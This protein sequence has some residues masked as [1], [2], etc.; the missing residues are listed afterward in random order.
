MWPYHDPAAQVRPD[1][2]DA[3]GHGRGRCDD[4][5]RTAGGQ[6]H[7]RRFAP[8]GCPLGR[9]EPGLFAL[10]EEVQR[11]AQQGPP[12]PAG[13]DET[14]IVE[15]HPSAPGRAAQLTAH[16]PARSD[17]PSR[18]DDLDI[19]PPG[20][21]EVA[22]QLNQEPSGAAH[23]RP[24]RVHGHRGGHCRTPPSP[25]SDSSTQ[26]DASSRSGARAA[27]A[28]H[29]TGRRPASREAASHHRTAMALRRRPQVGV[30]PIPSRPVAVSRQLP[31]PG[32]SLGTPLRPPDGVPQIG[33]RIQDDAARTQHP[34]ALAQHR[35]GLGHV[36]K[37][38]RGHHHVERRGRERQPAPARLKP[39][40]RRASAAIA[41]GTQQHLPGD[42][43]S[44]HPEPGS[45]QGPGEF[46]CSAPEVEDSVPGLRV[47]A[48]GGGQAGQAP[49]QRSI[50][51]VLRWP[52]SCLG[53][54]KAQDFPGSA[55]RPGRI[56]AAGSR[57]ALGRHDARALSAAW[58][59]AR[60]VPSIASVGIPAPPC[61]ACRN[62]A[63]WAR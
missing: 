46:P 3:L 34:G 28:W 24:G 58:M 59:V 17:P 50:R 36:F 12:L 48:D 19:L 31:H 62:A 38:A 15:R 61:T 5:V 60:M 7:H 6:V 27:P 18:A 33:H 42:V 41:G 57:Q 52:G 20:A 40:P 22:A 37:H 11:I 23:L 43:T 35:G 63:A 1:R 56:W 10:G 55:V 51:S 13:G 29:D 39:Y 9:V 21:L 53:L 26:Q 14:D 4:H 16:Q 32:Q 2:C 25:V 47:P 45:R 30:V 54:E 44:G 49:G 8:D